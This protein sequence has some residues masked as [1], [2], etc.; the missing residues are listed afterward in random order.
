MISRKLAIAVAAS[1][2]LALGLAACGGSDDNGG[3]STASGL[4]GEI[5][6]DGSSTVGPLTEKIAEGFQESNPDVKVAV[7]TSGTSGGFE[8]FCAGETDINDASRPIEAPEKK[9]C[10]SKSITYDEVQVANDALTVMINPD[11]P[12]KCMT[13]DQLSQVWNK[14]STVDSWSQIK[15]LKPPYDESL[16][17]FGPGHRLGYVRLL[18]R[19]DQR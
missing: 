4:S 1:G 12:V 3:S 18:H 11:N 15:G 17:L 7:G 14:G 19:C 10:A 8:K 9:A 6:V 2:A 16:E 13:V 5:T